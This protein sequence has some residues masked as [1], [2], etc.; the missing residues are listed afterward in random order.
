MIVLKFILVLYAL[1]GIV[2][3]IL[4]GQLTGFGQ[5]SIGILTFG[6]LVELDPRFRFSY[7]IPN[8]KSKNQKKIKNGES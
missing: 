3:Q 6:F 5:G 8:A 7:M 2:V 4:I 1:I